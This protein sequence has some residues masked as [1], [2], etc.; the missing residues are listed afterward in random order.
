MEKASSLFRSKNFTFDKSHVNNKTEY[1]KEEK[2][3]IRRFL[4]EIFKKKFIVKHITKGVPRR[5][6]KK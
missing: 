1:S 5:N 3:Q 6:W 2:N 4:N